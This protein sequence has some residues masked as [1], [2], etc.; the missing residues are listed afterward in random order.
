MSR[1]RAQEILT[2]G[3]GLWGRLIFPYHAM[4]R[5][6]SLDLFGPTELMIMAMYQHNKRKWKKVLDIGGNLG[7][8]SILMAKLGMRV[9]TFEPDSEHFGRLVANLR[10]NNVWNMVDAQMAAVHTSEGQ[11]E[12][13]RVL[14][15]LTGN[16]LAGYKDS[17]GPRETV[18]VPTVDCRGLWDWADF[19]KIDSEGNEA[20]LCETMSAKDM[21]HMQAVCEVR[22]AK[23][24]ERIYQHFD[25]LR[26]PMWSQ[27]NDWK[28]V[29]ALT[30]M[31]TKNREGSL[32][33]GHEG[34]W[35]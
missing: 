24:A 3:F 9:R 19:A 8:H 31:P 4:G 12:F 7:L 11:H 2:D 27:K 30:Q 33:I 1:A 21:R 34:P 35:V 15:N 6:D 32:F 25:M 18:M 13:V 20:D 26:V 23:N 14:D 29:T 28:Q 10:A 16:H 22:D 17:Y 5:I